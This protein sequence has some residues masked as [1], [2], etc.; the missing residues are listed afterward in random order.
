MTVYSWEF[1]SGAIGVL[2]HAT[3]SHGE[4][5]LTEFEIW[6]DGLLICLVDPYRSV[7][8]MLFDILSS[9]CKVKIYDGSVETIHHFD[10]DPYLTEDRVFLESVMTRDVSAIKSLY[11]DAT[12]TYKLSYVIQNPSTQQK[13]I[14]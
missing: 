10:D 2:Q 12:E 3:L 9:A 7:T 14:N 4:K 8:L 6:C 13:R 5:Y 1:E 11:A